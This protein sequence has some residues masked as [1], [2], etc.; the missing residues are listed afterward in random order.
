MLTL[1][2]SKYV[3]K[4]QRKEK[5]LGLAISRHKLP[6]QVTSDM[7]I[8]VGLPPSK[9]NFARS[10]IRPGFRSRLDIATK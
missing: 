3:K 9:S 7:D 4:S 8:Y 2:A 1:A 6:L 10:S 5:N